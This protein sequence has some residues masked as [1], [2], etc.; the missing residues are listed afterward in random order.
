LP[1]PRNITAWRLPAHVGHQLHA[2]LGA[3]QRAA[4]A[5]VLQRV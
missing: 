3:H 4:F 2:A 5:L 1:R